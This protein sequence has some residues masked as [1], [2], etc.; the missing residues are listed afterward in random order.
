MQ[1]KAPLALDR[2]DWRMPSVFLAGSIE[3][4]VAKDWQKEISEG[5]H[6]MCHREPLVLNPR[7]DHWDPKWEQDYSNQHFREQVQW[8]LSALDRA[9]WVFVHL[10]HDTLSPITLMEI[11]LHARRGKMFVSC[12]AGFWRRGNVQT[13]CVHYRVPLFGDINAAFDALLE[14]LNG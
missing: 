6:S 3:M 2:Q 9:D 4:G 7:R 11:G 1:V 12:P 14:K 10:Q 5:L 8:E 13:V